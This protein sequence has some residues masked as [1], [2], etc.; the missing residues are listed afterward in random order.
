ML[1]P[2]RNILEATCDNFIPGDAG[3]IASLDMVV[4]GKKMRVFTNNKLWEASLDG[5]TFKRAKSAGMYGAMPWMR[6][7]ADGIAHQKPL[8]KSYTTELAFD[9]GISVP[10]GRI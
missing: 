4:G 8:K 7:G 2:G 9:L 3:F 6:F 1:K 10:P 5:K